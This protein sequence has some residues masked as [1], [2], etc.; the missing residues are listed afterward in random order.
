MAGAGCRTEGRGHPAARAADTQRTEEDRYPEAAPYAL[1]PPAGTWDQDRPRLSLRP[2][3]GAFP[4]DQ[5][6]EEEGGHHRFAA[7]DEEV[8]EPDKGTCGRASRAG[9]GKRHH[10]CTAQ[11]ALGISEPDHRCLFQEDSGLGVQGRPLGTGMYRCPA[12]GPAAEAVSGKG[13]HSPLRS[14]F[15]VL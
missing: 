14:G 13:S 12:D 2:D 5:D 8:R 6:Q 1:R 10:L 11:Q 7:L 9:L 4:T 3:E 15:A